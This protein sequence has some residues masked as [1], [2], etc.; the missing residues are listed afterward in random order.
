MDLT[1][2]QKTDMKARFSTDAELFELAGKALEADYK[3][4][5]AMDKYSGGFA[6]Y[7]FPVGEEHLNAGHILTN[8]G[9]SYFSAM[10]GLLY[11]HYVVFD[12]TWGNREA[13]G[14]DED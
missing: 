6:A 11:R 1:E 5:V 2:K 4:T 14:M 7:M 3:I 9:A 13:Q 10:R 12:Q 8:R